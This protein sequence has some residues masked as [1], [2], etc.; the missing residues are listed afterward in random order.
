MI[1]CLHLM[2]ELMRT[3]IASL[4]FRFVWTAYFLSAFRAVPESVVIPP[5][6]HPSG[7][8]LLP[9]AFAG[10]QYI[11]GLPLHR[12]PNHVMTFQLKSAPDWITM[13][14]NVLSKDGLLNFNVPDVIVAQGI[15]QIS[16]TVGIWDQTTGEELVGQF[17]V[18]VESGICSGTTAQLC[19]P[20]TSPFVVGVSEKRRPDQASVKSSPDFH[21]AVLETNI[22]ARF[23]RVRDCISKDL[24]LGCY[25]PESADDE[26]RGEI[27]NSKVIL[28]GSV[29]RADLT[30]NTCSDYDWT[31][32]TLSEESSNVLVFGP[33]DTSVFCKDRSVHVIVPVQSIW[34]QLIGAKG[35]KQDPMRKPSPAPPT[36]VATLQNCGTDVFSISI[37]PCDTDQNVARKILYQSRWVYNRLAQPSVFQGTISFSPVIARGNTEGLTYDL[38][39]SPWTKAGPGWL[40]LP[41]VFEKSRSLGSNLNSFTSF[42]SYQLKSS[43]TKPEF[44]TTKRSETDR[45]WMLGIRPID[46][47]LKLGPEFAPTTTEDLNLATGLTIRQPFVVSGHRQAS[48]LT[49]FPAVGVEGGR[50][51]ETH[52]PGES[53]TFFRYFTGVDASMRWPFVW[54]PNFTGTKP[55]TLDYSYRTTWLASAEPYTE[56]PP[57]G[58]GGDE[59][60][61]RRRRSITRITLN[62]PW[63]PYVGFKVTVL[64]GSLPPDFRSI[65]YTV[66]FGLSL[67]STGTAEH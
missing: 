50:H 7:E 53:S 37:R 46:Y 16:L 36:G 17:R 40:G 47:T 28:S 42:L 63:S 38:Q 44:A 4:T 2:A 59:I 19:G 52:L 43:K 27:I 58:A 8:I 35:D 25:A 60:L 21:L 9:P 34:A 32:L 54:A 5:A 55:I 33:Q 51:L 15:T 6:K 56:V 45:K 20:S 31:T 12:T 67:S 22:A 24:K 49:L 18:P 48:L 61:S 13:Q 1:I 14:G 39:V 62:E 64:R 65:G 41:T 57:T 30:K 66:L 26:I 11:Y 29:L 10:T 23:D 3:R